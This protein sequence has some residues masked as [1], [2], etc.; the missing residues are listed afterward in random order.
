M[1]EQRGQDLHKGKD[2]NIEHDF[3]DEVVVV[4]Q[5]TGSAVHGFGE[6]KPRYDT[7]DNKKYEGIFLVLV[8]SEA[9][10]EDKPVD[11]N[12]HDGLDKCPD[13]TKI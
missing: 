5:R 11:E 4:D 6:E 13:H 7:H 8:L 3:F 1:H 2:V 9:Y 12:G 10:R